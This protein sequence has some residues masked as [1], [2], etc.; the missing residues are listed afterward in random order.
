MCEVNVIHEF[1][2]QQ[3]VSM[4]LSPQ[5]KLILKGPLDYT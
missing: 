1:I 3:V 4:P 5:F 2:I